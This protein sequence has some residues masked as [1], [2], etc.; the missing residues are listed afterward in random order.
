LIKIGEG[1]ERKGGKGG[2]GK[3]TWSFD[4]WESGN[5]I[6]KKETLERSF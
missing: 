5:T 2:K 4:S 6:E 3:K 1:K